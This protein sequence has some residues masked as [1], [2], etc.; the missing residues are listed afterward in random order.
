MVETVDKTE[1][2]R[3]AHEIADK[4]DAAPADEKFRTFYDGVRASPIPYLPCALEQDAE[5]LFVRAY[6]ALY[7][8]GRASVPLTVGLTM[9]MYNLS[10]LATLPV[11]T[12]P[13]FEL[14][15]K[16]LVD[17]I[18]KYRSLLAI[19]SFGENIK[20]KDAPSRNVV[21]EQAPDGNFVCRGR[22]AF[23]S[24]ASEADLLL[25]S[26]II[27]EHMGM[28][29]T[30]V[31]DQPALEV[32][33]PLFGGAMALTDTRPIEFKDLVIKR[34]NVLSVTD[35][36]TDHV[37]FYATA[38]FEALVTAAYLGGA[39]RA[40]EEV[41][42][43]SRSVHTY[44]DETPLC[45]L[46]G[47]VVDAG[48]L[49]IT[50]RSSLAQ[51]RSFGTCAGRYCRRVREAAPAPELDQLANDLMDCGAAVKYVAT[52]NAV[53]VVNGAR[54]LVGT[55]SMTPRHPIYALSEQIL[56][57]PLH[58]TIPAMYERSAGSEL[59]SEVPFLG[60]FEWGLG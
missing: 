50:L 1:V 3:Q 27:G 37:S 60:L 44:E 28:F 54:G 14:R 4:V 47:F 13:E 6:E 33:L 18:R 58:P 21:V 48:R 38:W 12:A 46:D 40:L 55:R 59:L 34:R 39:C 2:R 31:K 52:K 49:A 43:F 26:G 9:H 24:M 25:F 5:E 53:D 15:R 56:F 51:A 30:S 36:L 23:Q 20:S 10:A 57:G 17:T 41:R 22:K 29:Y 7:I 45:E 11:P 19:S 35:D 32:G 16:I 8:L 42:T